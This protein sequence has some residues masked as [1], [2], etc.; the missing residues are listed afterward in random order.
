LAD[1][2]DEEEEEPDGAHCAAGSMY[3]SPLLAIPFCCT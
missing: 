2:E 3:A 1:E